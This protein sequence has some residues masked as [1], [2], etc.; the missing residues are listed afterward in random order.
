MK[1]SKLKIAIFEAGISQRQ[2]ARETNIPESYISMAAHGKYNLNPLQVEKI[3]KAL[4]TSPKE[5]S[6]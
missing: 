5:I 4:R 1:N 2:L 3:A 6:N